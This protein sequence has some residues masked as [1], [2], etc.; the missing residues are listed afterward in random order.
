MSTHLVNVTPG[1]SVQ[2]LCPP[3]SLPS[4]AKLLAFKVTSVARLYRSRLRS[5]RI[6]LGKS[7]CLGFANIAKCDLC[8]SK[9]N[10]QEKCSLVK[11]EVSLLVDEDLHVF[12]HPLLLLLQIRV[13]PNYLYTFFLLEWSKPAPGSSRP[14]PGALSRSGFRTTNLPRTRTEGYR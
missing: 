4:A 5:R 7:S 11:R 3:P 6:E 12:Q 8:R 14:S 13:S 9:T 2:S 1:L 10:S